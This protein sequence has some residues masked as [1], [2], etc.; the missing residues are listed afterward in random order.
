M[1][2]IEKN[3]MMRDKLVNAPSVEDAK[4]NLEREHTANNWYDYGKALSKAHR[5]QEAI[6]VYSQGLVEFPFSAL[7]YFGR[8][9]RYMSVSFEQAIADFT[10]AIRIE[11]DVN[12]YWYY[13]A[14]TYNTHGLYREA[15]ADFRQAMKY[16]Q[17]EDHYSMVDWIFTSYVDLG[18]MEGA[19]R[20]LDLVPD[21]LEVPDMDWDYKCRVRLYK[22]ILKPEDMLNEDEIRK[23]VPDPNDDLLLD[24]VTLRFGMFVYYTYIGDTQK[25]NE[26]LLAIVNKPYEGA[27][28]TTK[29]RAYAEERGLI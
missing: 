4:A 26:Q 21:D 25:A 29:A 9:C 22:G 10:M 15:I 27:F 1:T 24:I 5:N 20:A 14:V 16:A 13:R 2:T 8:G 19:R 11:E 12:L 23:H 3:K 17:P 7:L 6:D 18:D 28:A